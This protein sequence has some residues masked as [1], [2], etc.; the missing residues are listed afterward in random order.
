[1]EPSTQPTPDRKPLA[2][3]VR[4]QLQGIA[5]RALT[6]REQALSGLPAPCDDATA[7][8]LTSLMERLTTCDRD[9]LWVYFR[10]QEP[11]GLADPIA[12]VSS[13]FERL[14]IEHGEAAALRDVIDHLRGVSEVA[15]DSELFRRLSGLLREYATELDLRCLSRDPSEIYDDPTNQPTPASKRANT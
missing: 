15:R 4:E 7:A 12:H 8:V 3:V 1:M 11:A 9:L 6:I 5:L 14:R 10:R 13:G 2:A